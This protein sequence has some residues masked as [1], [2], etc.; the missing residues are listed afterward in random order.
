M[1]WIASS[2]AARREQ[3]GRFLVGTGNIGGIAATTGPGIGL[4]DDEGF[5]L[6]DRALTE[7][8]KIIDT[9]DIYAGGNSERVVGAWH[10]AHSTADALI[11]TKTGVTADGPNLAPERVR[12]QLQRSIAVLGRVDLYLAHA[13]DP[14]TA[15]SDSLPVFSAAVESGHIRAYGLSN[16]DEAALSSALET[17]DRLDL[18]R[19]ELVQNAYSLIVRD[20]D[21]SV[22]PLVEA[23]GLAYTPYSP[24]ANGILAG[25]YSKGEEVTRGARASASPRAP[26][27]LA[28]SAVMSQVRKFDQIAAEW[29]ASSAGLALAWVIHHPVVTAPIIG[30]STA[31]QW[32]GVREALQIAWTAELGER[33]SEIFPTD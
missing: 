19:P 6:I 13:V 9:S 15:W 31:S 8:A 5:N 1:S 3:F 27:L 32:Q 12:Q 10:H 23:E 30:I 29:N 25:R 16:V 22:L 28:D 26:G 18:A 11:Q 2:P 14:H 17:A 21:R 4:S 24:L 20:D 7:G 33:I